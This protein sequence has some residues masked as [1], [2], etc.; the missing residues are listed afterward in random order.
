MNVLSVASEVFPL[1]KTGGLADVIGALPPALAEQGISVRTLVPG[2]PAVTEAIEA[3]Q[4]V[5]SDTDWFGGAARLLTGRAGGLDLL[6]LDA[7]HLYA[8]QG[9]PYFGPDGRDWPDNAIRFA[10]LSHM[11][12]DICGGVM[13]G[14]APDVLHVH[15]WQTGLAPA[16]LHYRGGARPGTV[17]TVHNLAF[18][19]KAPRNLLGALD[20]PPQSFAIDGVEF[21]GTIGLLKAGLQF[22]DR[23]TT[24]SPTYAAEIC[25]ADAGMG[26]DGLLRTRSSVLSGILNG[27]DTEVW[28]PATDL[29]LAARFD[30]TTLAKRV[31]NKA[32]LQARLGLEQDAAAPLFGVVSRLT[33]QK[34]A[35]LVLACLPVL[36]ALDAKLALVGT[37]DAGIESGLRFAAAQA[38]NRIGCVIGYDEGLAHLV[39][40]GAD[41]LLVPSRF[42]P[43][44]LTQ[45]C[46]LRYGAVPVVSRVGG[47]A[48]TVIDANAAALAAGVATGVQFSPVNA[49]MLDMAL[50]RTVALF[51]EPSLWHSLQENGMATDVSWR[52]PARKYAA[53]YRDLVEARSR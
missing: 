12:A 46:A 14:Y 4:T 25:T 1:V 5:H 7:P 51:R 34:G 19:G 2:Y 52:G 9:N 53:L 26:F 36:Q 35:D 27:V 15:D 18:P 22:A 50:R 8:R 45:L 43:C 29:S 6:V 28:D 49:G 33:W 20:L 3:V 24:V 21:Y 17:M 16:Y 23:I 11:A 47:L 10:A 48:D 32:A 30:R 13:Q 37:G 38:P 40:A 31:A 44:G 39:Q 41:A 42:E